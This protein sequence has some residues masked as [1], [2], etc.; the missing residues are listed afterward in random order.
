M[1]KLEQDGVVDGI[2][3]EDSDLV[4]LG[5]RLLLTKLSRKSNGEY[6]VRVFERENFFLIQIL[7]ARNFASIQHGGRCRIVSRK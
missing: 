7:T 5:A 1:V 4:A 3:S 2:I 6:R